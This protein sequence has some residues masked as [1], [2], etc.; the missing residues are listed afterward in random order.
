[1]IV[2]ENIDHV[3]LAVSDIE[4]SIEFYRDFFGFD[5]VEHMSG[6]PDALLQV[7]D[8]RLK[9]ESDDGKSKPSGYVAFY[10]DEEDFEDALD[11]IEENNIPIV[12]GPEDYRGGKRV[13]IQDLS[14]NKVA[15]CHS[16]K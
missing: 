2:I 5:V 16:D 13:I 6:S 9:L 1:M 15:L 12:S 11:E 7:G 10:V 3:C 8:I 14:G 4:K